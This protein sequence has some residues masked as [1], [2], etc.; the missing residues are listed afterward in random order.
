MP[1]IGVANL[2][3]RNRRV[4][5][6]GKRLQFVKPDNPVKFEKSEIG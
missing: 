1:Y 6:G 5:N 4:Q 3:I 2:D